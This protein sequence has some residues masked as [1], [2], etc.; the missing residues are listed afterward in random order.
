MK[1]IFCKN[2]WQVD[3]VH[4]NYRA[5]S[6]SGSCVW[7]PTLKKL[8]LDDDTIGFLAKN[9]NTVY[10]NTKL[11]KEPSPYAIGESGAV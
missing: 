9:G 5:T 10:I 7:Y 1:S 4:W 6:P 3:F 8:D 11:E 2:G